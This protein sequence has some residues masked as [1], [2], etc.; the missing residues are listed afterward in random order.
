MR[1][2]DHHEPMQR[3]SRERPCAVCGKHD[4]CLQRPDGS[5]AICARIEEGS[6][7]RAGDAGWLHVLDPTAPRPFP[8]ARALPQTP[9]GPKHD[10]AV[11]H[12]RYREAAPDHINALA[13][14]LS[15]SR[16][17]LERLEV[18][19]DPARRWWTFPERDATGQI[20]G[21]IGRNEAGQKRRYSGA[22]CG[23]CY[24]ADWAAG[25]G[26]LLLVEGA[27]DMAAVLT[28]GLPG[29]ARPSNTGGITLLTDLLSDLSA[30][31]PIVVISERDKKEDGTWPGKSGAISTAKQLAAALEREI[32]WSLPPDNAKDTR[33]W[34]QSVSSIPA[35]R[36]GPLY[37]DGLD[38]TPVSPPVRYRYQPP[39][40][41]TV[42]LEEWRQA[43]LEARIASL[44]VPGYYLDASPTG[45]G[46]SHI[47][48][49]VV[50]HVLRGRG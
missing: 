39:S 26:P 17:A 37:L 23:L 5:A 25:T 27:S 45:A 16:D 34:L 15:V 3:V 22:K 38:P 46:K 1:A 20:V 47:E 8:Q 31:R 28:M 13:A 42:D 30:D 6:L 40:A 33:A 44:A 24:P 29:V 10:W 4:W 35:D 9:S 19:Y 48:L 12:Q 11:W 32:E 43:M 41:Q 21:L 18:G 50:Q 36:W 14:K 2:A 7:K 49:R